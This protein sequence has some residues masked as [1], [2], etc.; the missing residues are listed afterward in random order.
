[1]IGPLHLAQFNVAQAQD[2]PAA[3]QTEQQAAPAAAQAAP[4]AAPAA[5]EDTECQTDYQS[6]SNQ[7]H[8]RCSTFNE[9]NFDFFVNTTFFEKVICNCCCDWG[10]YIWLNSTCSGSRCS[11]SRTN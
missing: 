9:F 10:L 7:T 11:C 5:E 6:N 1:V 8:E 3:E 2:A 4:A